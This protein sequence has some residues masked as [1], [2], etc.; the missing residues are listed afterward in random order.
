MCRIAKDLKGTTLVC[1]ACPYTGHVHDFN[2]N[3]P[4]PRTLA[5]QK[6]LKNVHAEHSRETHV[7]AMAMM[8]ERQHAPR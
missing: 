1:F 7:G 8:I 6:M 4:N 5:A 3:I 2:E